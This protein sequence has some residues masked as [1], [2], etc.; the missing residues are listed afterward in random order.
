MYKIEALSSGSLGL[1][2]ALGIGGFPK[3]RVVEIYGGNSSGKTSIAL[4]T[5]RGCLKNKG[6]V[7]FFDMERAFNPDFAEKLGVDLSHMEVIE[8]EEDDKIPDKIEK[9]KSNF[10]VAL[11]WTGEEC[12]DAVIR[13]ANIF[14]IAVVDSIAALVPQ[15]ETEQSIADDTM[16]L[17]ARMLSKFLRVATPRLGK[18]LV[19]FIN[20]TRSNIGGYGN[21]EVTPGGKALG[22]YASQRVA[23]RMG[24]L[25]KDK[26]RV[27]G[28]KVKFKVQKNKVSAPFRESFFNFYYDSGIDR[29]DEL[30]TLGVQCDLITQKGGG[31]FEY[32]DIKVRGRDTLNEELRK[33]KYIPE[34]EKQI[35]EKLK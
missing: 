13:I 1:D 7:G 20:Q 25:I 35:M 21:P 28:H 30:I 8:S 34:L 14:D 19:L 16:A 2:V 10:V 23:V 11:P 22:Y 26:E 17:Q 18:T 31:N 12:L 15:R 32:K 4:S 33:S 6:R 9:C 24:E 27:I 29:L 5:V 3:G